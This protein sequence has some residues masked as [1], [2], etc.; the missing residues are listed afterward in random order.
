[1]PIR[2]EDDPNYRDQ[3]RNNDNRPRDPRQPRNPGGGG[4]GGGGIGNML[5][6]FLPMLLRNPKLLMIALGIGA[7]LYFGGFFGGGGGFTDNTNPSNVI[8]NDNENIV[9]PFSTGGFLDEKKYDK[10]MVYTALADNKKNPLPERVSLEQYA[11]R[12]LNQGRQGSCVGWSSAYAAQTIQYAKAYGVEPDRVAFSPSYL[13]N[14]IALRGC[15]GTYI[16]EAMKV[17][18]SRGTLPLQAFP[19]DESSCSEK[20]NRAEQQEAYKYRIKGNNRLSEGANKYKTDLVA[21]K[22]HLA[23]GTPVVIGMQVGGTFMTAM[24]GREVWNPSRNDYNMRGFGGHAMCVIGYDDYKSGGAFQIMNSWGPEWGKNGIGWVKYDDFYH[25]NKE[26]YGLHPMSDADEKNSNVFA[27]GFGVI[28]QATGRNI[29]LERRGPNLFGTVRPVR[30]GDKFKIEFAN[31]VE[32]YTYL[33]G[34][35][36]DGSSYVLFPYTKKHSPYCGVTGT[37]VFPRDKNLVPD[38]IGNRDYFAV[39]VTKQPVDYE[40][41]N[42]LINSTPGSSYIDKI[43]R[44]IGSDLVSDADFTTA[45]GNVIFQAQSDKN[46]AAFVIEVDKR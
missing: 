34:Q 12:R 31:T 28:D 41:V 14:Q 42:A 7:F 36:T 10:A 35:E 15:Q 4:R 19:Y 37:R 32:C 45:E 11:P 1:M 17:M 5:V 6:M 24:R 30:P 25:F 13:Y 20:P 43:T 8:T 33:F 23:A 27:A 39:I 44:A 40:K 46:V 29:T 3:N 18:E 16:H 2:M 22:Q 21:V 9:S 26:A 38:N